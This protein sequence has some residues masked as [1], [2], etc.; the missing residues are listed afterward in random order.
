MKKNRHTDIDRLLVKRLLNEATAAECAEVDD[1]RS[2]SPENRQYLEDLQRILAETNPAV[3]AGRPDEHE[4]WER[5]KNSPVFP[6][7]RPRLRR[8]WLIPMGSF[9]YRAVAIVVLLSFGGA[10][11]WWYM[12]GRSSGNDH[13]ALLSLQTD[14]GILTDTLPDGSWVTLNKHSSLIYPRQFKGKT[15]TVH[16]DGEGFFHIAHRDRESFLVSLN[17]VTIRDLGTSF[18]VKTKDGQTEVIVETGE[19]EVTSGSNST[20]AGPGEKV[21]VSAAHTIPNKTIS[22]DALYQYY[23]TKTFVCRSTH[24][25]ELVAVLNEAYDAHIVIEGNSAGS[26]PL[27]AVYRNESLEHILDL[28][29]KSLGLS[30]YK[31]GQEIFLK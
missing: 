15:R 1:W 26:L 29:T 16:L 13:E 5:F 11:A 3:P 22:S 30:W 21:I 27:T 20:R 10:S 18:N 9:V 24:L 19:V 31:K 23:R 25:Q 17:G 12:T 2:R 28:V 14:S 8:G 4:A 6:A 7:A